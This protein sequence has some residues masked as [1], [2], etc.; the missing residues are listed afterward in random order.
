MGRIYHDV[1]DKNTGVKESIASIYHRVNILKKI[2][3]DEDEINWLAKGSASEKEKILRY[4]TNEYLSL[5]KYT[6]D[7][8]PKNGQ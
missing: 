8:I 1:Q 2:E 6:I 7:H 4:T 3:S 5:L